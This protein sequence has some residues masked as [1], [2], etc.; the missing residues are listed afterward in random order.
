MRLRVLSPL[1]WT[2]TV[3]GGNKTL[4]RR[5]RYYNFHLLSAH[6]LIGLKHHKTG[7]VDFLKSV[8]SIAIMN[9]NWALMGC[10]SE[11]N[12]K[13]HLILFYL[14]CRKWRLYTLL[15]RQQD[16]KWYVKKISTPK[17]RWWSF[18]QLPILFFKF[19]QTPNVKNYNQCR[20]SPSNWRLKPI[21]EV[22]K[23]LAC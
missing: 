9:W 11:L 3:H 20:K 23:K 10:L 1:L 13:R 8:F 2:P 12:E 7:Y 17:A 18:F 5:R 16:C 15:E 19:V 22:W 6:L 4:F 14:I 21:P